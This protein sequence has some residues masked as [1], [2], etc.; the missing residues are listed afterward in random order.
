[1]STGDE[2]RSWL[3]R[4]YSGVA[5]NL[6]A[7]SEPVRLLDRRLSAISCLAAIQSQV[8]PLDDD[9]FR[10]GLTPG[11]RITI[12]RT[13]TW[14][15]AASSEVQTLLGL[16]GTYTGASS[17]TAAADPEGVILPSGLRLAAPLWSSEGYRP[18]NA[19][20]DVVAAMLKGSSSSVL[21][22][23]PFATAWTLEATA[24][25]QT[26]DIAH[27]G[28]WVGR[29]RVVDVTRQRQGRLPGRVTLTLSMQGV[30]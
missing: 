15:L 19:S 7:A 9:E 5:G 27:A 22:D 21:L 18:A 10:W 6:F 23:V 12:R 1:M 4:V 30:A 14:E 17:Y 29:G 20:G 25:G 2:Q 8:G 26:Y 13:A 11:G 28:R 24:R 3:A 16:T